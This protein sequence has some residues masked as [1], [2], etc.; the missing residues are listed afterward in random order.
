MLSER[1]HGFLPAVRVP[2]LTLFLGEFLALGD[3]FLCHHIHNA[4]RTLKFPR[5]GIGGTLSHPGQRECEAGDQGR[6]AEDHDDER[7]LGA[8]L[9]GLPAH[10]STAGGF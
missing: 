2:G 8:G 3:G 10:G 1:P 5:E 6:G 7:L 9:Q 4:Q